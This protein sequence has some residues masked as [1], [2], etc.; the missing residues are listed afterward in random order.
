MD[1]EN[2]GYEEKIKFL[3]LE[4]S[5]YKKQYQHQLDE[6]QKLKFE[7]K[8]I[9]D[10]DMYKFA[11]RYYRIRDYILSGKRKLILKKI[12][13]LIKGVAKDNP[14]SGLSFSTASNSIMTNSKIE[15][16]DVISPQHTLYLA[17]L[18]Q[19]AF[20][21]IGIDCFISIGTPDEFIDI[22]YIIIAP[23][24][25]TKFPKCYIAYQM[26]QSTSERWFDEK[27]HAILNN[28][29]SV[30]DYS[31]F[32]IEFFRTSGSIRN[33]NSLFYLPVD[34]YPS[35]SESSAC[36]E[37]EYDVLFYGDTNSPRRKRI[38]EAISKKFDVHICYDVFG[39]EL[40]SEIRKA[41]VLLNIHYY[42]DALLETI[43][44]YE[45][46]SLNSCVI[47]S[48]SGKDGEERKRLEG[49][50]DFIE[51]DDI[52]AIIERISY[53]LNHDDERIKKVED[54]ER[55]LSSRSSAF[56]FFFYRY[57]LAWDII[58]F[59]Q[60]YELSGDYVSLGCDRICLN[61]PE[62]VERRNYFDSIN[63]YG[64]KVIPGLRHHLGWVGCG[65]SYKLI[66]R[67]SHDEGLNSVAVCEDDVVFPP[68]FSER[69]D[70]VYSFLS[71]RHWSFFS[72][73][74]AD[75]K[76]VS[77]RSVNNVEDILIAQV[78]HLVSMVFNIYNSDALEYISNWNE[79]DR[80]VDRNAIDR[81][82]ENVSFVIYI[83]IPF[84][85]GHNEN[86]NSVLWGGSNADL[87]VD[88]ISQAEK[89]LENKIVKF[90]KPVN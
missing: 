84:L 63:K 80:D 17:K 3:T 29:F 76:K 21:Q 40:Y 38:L 72:G 8:L 82:I 11:L 24:T 44:I 30:L 51:P 26:E 45:A 39:E 25:L 19:H 57:L 90:G 23:Q 60:F 75:V 73:L 35:F 83:M 87:Y 62:V 41:K 86:L 4:S 7:L 56:D 15:R 42:E 59:E 20:F 16:I 54:N 53:W 43:R 68:D 32:N 48:E 34:Y 88:M 61:L 74:M 2:S 77:V 71:K 36:S 52:D 10:S 89:E 69:L 78:D 81:Y 49:F 9:H 12:F 50:V 67:R 70:L 14:S 33:K 37:K 1:K 66:A 58:S 65:L 79:Q 22:P 5:F 6:N 31:L 46:L 28:A 27:Y 55:I 13:G 64:F 47:V 85:V 18:I